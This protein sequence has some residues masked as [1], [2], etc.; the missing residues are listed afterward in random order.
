[1]ALYSIFYASIRKATQEKLSLGLLLFDKGEVYF[2]TSEA[3][4]KALKSFMSKEDFLVVQQSFNA[5]TK[6]ILLHSHPQS[7][8]SHTFYKINHPA[9]SIDY[10]NYLS[11]YKNNL[12]TYSEPKPISI[13]PTPETFLRLFQNFVGPD[14]VP[15]EA[16]KKLTTFAKLE[17]KFE[18]NISRYFNTHFTMTSSQVPNLVAPVKVDLLGKN[19]QDVLVRTIDTDSGPEK[20][21]NEV[22]T[23]YML[24]DTYRRNNIPCQE[25]VV[26]E[27][28]LQKFK[29]QHDIWREIKNSGSFNYLDISEVEKLK[30]Y[31]ETN[32]VKPKVF[33]SYSHEDTDDRLPF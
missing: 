15:A 13:E 27:E 11:K 18:G 16:V 9:F 14:L 26:A 30:E 31:A 2:K 8:F 23:F 1:M 24:V 21:T 22:S 33:I 20:M 3:K 6:Q 7:Y 5:V 32:H 29:P 19:G 10:I 28:P 4:L 25:F 12:V 17:S